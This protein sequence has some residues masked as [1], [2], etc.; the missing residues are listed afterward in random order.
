MPFP[1]LRRLQ[2]QFPWLNR[3]GSTAKEMGRPVL[4]TSLTLTAALLGLRYVGA[5]QGMELA[6]YDHLVRTQPDEGEDPRFLIVGIAESDIQRLQEWPISDHTLARL[7]TQLEQ[8]QPHVIGLDVMRDIPIGQGRAE[9]LDVLRRSDR[10][11]AVCKASEADDPGIA[12]P[13]SIAEDAVGF[14]DLAVDSGGTLRRNLLLLSPPAS[15]TTFPNQPSHLCSNPKNTLPSLSLQLA[16]HYVQKEGLVVQFTPSGELQIGA[17]RFPRFH[18]HL[19]GYQSADDSGY[20]VLL[21]YR[22][23]RRV[24]HQVSLIDVLEGR[25]DPALIR[26][27]IVMIGYTTPQAK[28]EFYTPYS[29]GEDDDQKMAGVLVHTQAT[30]QILSAVFDHRPMLWAWSEGIEG[31]WILGW[32]L[33][34]GVLAWYARHPIKFGLGAAIAAGTLYGICFVIFL[35]GGWIPLVPAGLSLMST[36]VGV[37]LVDR[38]NKSA[39]GKTVYRQVKTFLKLNIEIDQ[40]KL[41]KQV[42]EITE[43]DYFLDLQQKARALRNSVSGES[44]VNP[45]KPAVPSETMKIPEAK[46]PDPSQDAEPGEEI[47]YLKQLQQESRRLRNQNQSDRQD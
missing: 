47:D 33:V 23:Q 3:V 42:A 45:S 46:P 25:V 18:S 7:L 16:L 29:A 6:A 8:Q 5:F 32:A 12:P 13:P 22:S 35:Q 31:G 38:F 19:G 1:I 43:T 10:I 21:H 4:L 41:E 17:T 24:A 26:D 15:S 44:P 34:G 9:L 30:S 20:Q 11:V 36:A 39:Y 40:E 37:I 28:D 2:S 14:A 27:R